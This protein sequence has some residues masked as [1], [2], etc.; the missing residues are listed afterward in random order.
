M[1][2]RKE[3]EGGEVEKR[4]RRTRLRET[5][6]PLLTSFSISPSVIILYIVDPLR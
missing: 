4:E 3:R 6:S 5:L 1:E 2:R